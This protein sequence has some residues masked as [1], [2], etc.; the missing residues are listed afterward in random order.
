MLIMVKGEAILSVFFHL[1][2][3]WGST[4][5]GKKLLQGGQILSFKKDLFCNRMLTGMQTGKNRS[6]LF[7]KMAEKHDGVPIKLTGHSSK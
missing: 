6:S 7:K 3:E 1:S 2:S 5:K 4:L